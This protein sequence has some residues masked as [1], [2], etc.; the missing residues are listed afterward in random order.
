[1]RRVRVP[2]GMRMIVGMGGHGL[3]LKNGGVVQGRCLKG[4]SG[5]GE[6]EGESGKPKRELHS[7]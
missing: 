2:P 7:I 1:V 6:Q 5:G 3:T 4:G